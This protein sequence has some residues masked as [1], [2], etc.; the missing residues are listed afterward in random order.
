M[1]KTSWG[2]CRVAA[3]IGV[4]ADMFNRV[5]S[6][7]NAG[8]DAIVIDTGMDIPKVLITALKVC[9]EKFSGLDVIVGNVGTAEG[10]KLLVK[11]GADGVKV[12][13]VPVLFVITRVVTGA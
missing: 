6:L 3:G 13:W 4:T 10:A 8:V 2:D 12:E 11:N 9:K 7:V 5:S 1:Q